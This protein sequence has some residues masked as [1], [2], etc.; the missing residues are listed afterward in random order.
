M[1]ADVT[2]PK[3]VNPVSAPKSNILEPWLNVP[4]KCVHCGEVFEKGLPALRGHL[5]HCKSR[6]LNRFFVV[7][8]FLFAVR[9]NPLKR[10]ILSADGEIKETHDPKV[11]LGLLKGFQRYGLIQ[12]FSVTE[13]PEQSK[14]NPLFPDGIVSFGTL[15]KKLTPENMQIFKSDVEKQQIHHINIA[16]Q[17]NDNKEVKT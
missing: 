2:Q 5:G 12:S 13:L 14:T 16:E 6:Q 1:I 15:K 7:G 4:C 10:K 9:C 17:T 8:R 11:F 3:I